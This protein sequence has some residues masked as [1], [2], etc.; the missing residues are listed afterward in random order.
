ELSAVCDLNAARAEAC[1]RLFGAKA[2]YQDYDEMIE[3]AD[4]DAVFILTA[5]GTHVRF[6]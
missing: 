6:A 3:Q 2:A 4:I 1:V 5:P